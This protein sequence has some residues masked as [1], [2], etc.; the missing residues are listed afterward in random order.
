MD[1]EGPGDG[2]DGFALEDELTSKLRLVRSHFL[3]A[4]EGHAARHGGLPAF[5]GP[6]HDEGPLELRNSG[7]DRHDHYAG[8]RRRIGP[9][10]IKRL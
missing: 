7:E 4:T 8:R 9:G 1:V 5:V 2:A 3:R 10:L 6:A